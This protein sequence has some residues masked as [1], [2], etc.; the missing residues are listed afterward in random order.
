MAAP[1]S[2]GGRSENR[3]TLGSST[4]YLEEHPA[5]AQNASKRRSWN[6]ET[7]DHN[8]G[9]I[10]ST[11]IEQSTA[12]S[13]AP[14]PPQFPMGSGQPSSPCEL[15]FHQWQP[16][17]SHGKSKDKEAQKTS[18]DKSRSSPPIVDSQDRGEEDLSAKPRCQRC[19]KH[20]KGCDRQRPC[21]RCQD[22][23]VGTDGCISE[24]EGDGHRGRFGRHMGVTVEQDTKD[25][26]QSHEPDSPSIRAQTSSKYPSLAP[27]SYN[28]YESANAY[29]YSIYQPLQDTKLFAE[30]EYGCP[31]QGCGRYGIRGFSRKDHLS[32]HLRS[33]HMQ[34]IPQKRGA[35]SGKSGGESGKGN[36]GH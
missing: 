7:R 31:I 11:R 15:V 8:S 12:P 16:P 9:K 30:E 17:G 3:N 23:G 35:K 24:E 6:A 5:H 28:T 10:D 13:P 22:A 36:H 25:L 19:R 1:D 4:D 32:E 20:K 21:Q 29:R 27:D 2:A 33:V 26:A 34:D 18:F 14:L